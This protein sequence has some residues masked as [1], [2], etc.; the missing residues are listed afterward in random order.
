M[1][2]LELTENFQPA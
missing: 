2:M 1:Q